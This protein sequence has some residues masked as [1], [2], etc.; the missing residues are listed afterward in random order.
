MANSVDPDQSVLAPCCLLLYLIPRQSKA[1]I[2]SRRLQQM[3]FQ[4]HFFLG[5]LRV[6][7]AYQKINF[8]ISK[9]KQCYGSFEY[10]KY[11]FK[12]MGKKIFTILRSKILFI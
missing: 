10:P 8:L 1:I 12:L 5:A 2:C 7:S 4:I 11:M 6:K 3:T 9:P